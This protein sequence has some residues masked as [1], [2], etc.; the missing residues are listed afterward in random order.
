MDNNANKKRETR[1]YWV[2]VCREDR[3]GNWDHTSKRFCET[4]E[5]GCWNLRWL[6]QWYPNAFLVSMEMTQCVNE[7]E[8]PP[9][10]IRAKVI[11]RKG[12]IVVVPR[13][14]DAAKAPY[15]Q[16]HGPLSHSQLRG[17]NCISFKIEFVW[18]L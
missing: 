7:C 9:L 10:P 16:A 3:D 15:H 12:S 18:L 8:L 5:A 11:M 2:V 1:K 4:Y 14:T 6:R 13:D 17:R